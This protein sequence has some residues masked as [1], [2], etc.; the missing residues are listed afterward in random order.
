[1]KKN[2]FLS[3]IILLWMQPTKAEPVFPGENI[4][5]EK[6]HEH[7]AYDED[8]YKTFATYQAPPKRSDNGQQSSFINNF[9]SFNEFM[10]QA[11]HNPDWGYYGAGN[12]IF[13][14]GNQDGH[15]FTIPKQVSP[16][17][18]AMLAYQAYAMWRSMLE[19]GDISAQE[20]FHII[21][22][23]AGDGDFAY[24]ILDS[25][26]R[27]AE[28]ERILALKTHWQDFYSIVK[29]IIG[30]RAPALC[31]RQALRN[32]KFIDEQKCEIINTDAREA[33][34]HFTQKLKGLVVS[35]ELLD[36]FSLH[37]L[38]ITEYGEIKACFIV[39]VLHKNFF[40]YNINEEIKALKSMLEQHD[41]QNRSTHASI[42]KNHSNVDNNHLIIN[43]RDY[44]YLKNYEA[45][46]M[47]ELNPFIQLQ[48]IYLDANQVPEL[49]SYLRKHGNYLISLVQARDNSRNRYFY[50]N[51]SAPAFIQAAS[52]LLEAGFVITID[53]GETSI[54]HDWHLTFHSTA[55]RMYP[56]R[57]S[58][59]QEP[60]SA[61]IT[62][63]INFTDLY[64]AGKE[65]GLDVSFYGTQVDLQSN[66]IALDEKTII[67]GFD[68]KNPYFSPILS[69][70]LINFFCSS[71]N[72][73]MFKMLIQKKVKATNR[74]QILTA[75]QSLF[76]P[77]QS[78]LLAKN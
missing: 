6:Q 67:P 68:M 21:E 34:K 17:F 59:Y 58:C 64:F 78:Y 32:K 75:S 41:E 51:H 35:N 28:Q 24:D 49:E 30:E 63:D 72:S 52:D 2:F 62:C 44:F 73:H 13:K 57:T 25:I 27:N 19:S 31:Q 77:W 26:H 33:K 5:L 76:P 9:V 18:G 43:K 37:K 46:K 53:Y 8:I 56:E 65:C 47:A 50:I 15:F 71:Q 3:I 60:G 4:M 70:E 14:R 36:T 74:Y 7:L 20:K 22:F 12:V 45:M 10:E 11:L 61:D 55:V 69:D 29:Y 39:P 38:H 40:Q 42:L 16:A 54:I 1:M 66:S 48:E 23:G